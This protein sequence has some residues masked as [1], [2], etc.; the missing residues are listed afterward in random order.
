M[1]ELTGFSSNQANMAISF[2]DAKLVLGLGAPRTGTKWM[3]EYFTSH[4]EILMSPIRVLH[5]FDV[6]HDADARKQYDSQFKQRLQTLEEKS[7]QKKGPP[8]GRLEEMRDRVRMISD[9]GAYLD[10]FRKRWT[11]EKAFV[12][13]TP[14]YWGLPPAGY[15]EMLRS[16]KNVGFLFVM[17]NPIDRFWSGLRLRQ[18]REPGADAFR[19][20]EDRTRTVHNDAPGRQN[21]RGTITNLES[22]VPI[23]AIKYFFFE[24]LFNMKAIGELCAFMGAGSFPAPVEKAVNQA[25]PLPL[26]SE[27]RAKAFAALESDYRFVSEKFNGKLPPS[28]LHDIERFS[29]A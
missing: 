3:S 23:S 1:R 13:I 27:Q 28:W 4:P 19:E 24:E 15:E 29:A 12:D 22:V 8:P 5:Y 2:D 21:Y 25:D 16:H 11:G 7:A 17:R 6:R 9:P 14:A 18:M 26:N 10:F 20:F